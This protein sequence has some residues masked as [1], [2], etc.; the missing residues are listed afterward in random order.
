MSTFYI[1]YT[2]CLPGALLGT[3]LTAGGLRCALP[4]VSP[5]VSVSGGPLLHSFG[6][7][8]ARVSVGSAAHALLAI[9]P[10]A[11]RT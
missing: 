11:H 5:R 9:R 8:S 10:R 4:V 1:V 6:A 2:S 7:A 3:C